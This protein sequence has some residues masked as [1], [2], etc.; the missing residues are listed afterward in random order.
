MLS[1]LGQNACVYRAA[2]N[3]QNPIFKPF[4]APTYV[5]NGDA[6]RQREP[7]QP[8][9]FRAPMAPVPQNN[10]AT[11]SAQQDNFATAPQ[12]PPAQ[13][14]PVSNPLVDAFS[15]QLCSFLSL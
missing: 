12:Q 14:F 6:E 15:T 1:F 13:A 3:A 11:A 7:S 2:E 10:F 9:P 4:V 5:R 8:M